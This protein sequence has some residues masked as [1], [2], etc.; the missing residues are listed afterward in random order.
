MY[1][2]SGIYL[3]FCLIRIWNFEKPFWVLFCVV[4][5]SPREKHSIG[6][7][8]EQ[9]CANARRGGLREC[10][11]FQGLTQTCTVAFPRL[12]ALQADFNGVLIKEAIPRIV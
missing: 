8:R 4:F 10:S 6:N 5:V 9:R 12:S 2:S 7:I 11:L 1:V 3:A